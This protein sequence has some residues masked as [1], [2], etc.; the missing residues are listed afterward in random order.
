M[1]TI[2]REELK[3]RLITEGYADQYGFEQ[4]IDRLMNF[5][6]KPKEMLKNGWKRV[7]FLNLKQFKV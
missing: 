3:V 7:E 1:N 6:G 5:D 2:N 4:T